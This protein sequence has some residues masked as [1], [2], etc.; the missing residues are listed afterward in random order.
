MLESCEPMQSVTNSAEAAKRFELDHF[1][2]QFRDSLAEKIFQ[3]DTLAQSINLIR[4]YLVAGALLYVAFGILD[5]VLGGPA[6]V[7]ILTIRF[8]VVVPIVFGIYGLTYH[9]HFQ[10]IMQGALAVAMLT[11]GMGIIAMTAIMGPPF[12][13]LYYAGLIMVVSYCGSLIR[14]NFRYSALISIWL[15]FCYQLVGLWINPIPLPLFIS[16]DFFLG[17]ASGVGLFAGYIQELYLRKAYVA[18]KTVEEKNRLVSESLADA[19]RANKS[20]GEF[21]ATMSHELRTPLNAIIGFSDIIRRELFGTIKNEKYTEYARDI[22]ESGSHL[23]A[24]INDILDLAKAESGKL[25]LSE[26]EFDAAETL[27]TCIRMCQMRSDAAGIRLVFS[28]EHNEIRI[29]ADERLLLQVFSNLITN[30]IKFTPQG[31]TVRVQ[32]YTHPAKGAIFRIADT[33]IG[34]APENVDRVLRPFEQVETS[35]SRSHGGVGLGLP[36]AKRLTELHGGSLEIE[37]QIGKGTTLTV[38]L[39]AWR[40]AST[41]AGTSALEAVNAAE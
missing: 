23:L 29:F 24:I 19:M 7:S 40:L 10:K 14:L 4:V 28:S 2:L 11:S 39:P 20:K 30:A 38:T 16:N 32:I 13:S 27:R 22:H 8:G 33:G 3:I 25:E 18:Q 1:R 6:E 17:M 26:H 41:S 35:Y 37:S 15:F 12:N 5:V 36:Y 9:R 21:L 31:G 34:I